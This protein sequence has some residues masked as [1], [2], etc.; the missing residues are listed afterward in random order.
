MNQILAAW[1]EPILPPKHEKFATTHAYL[2]LIWFSPF[3]DFRSLA[4]LNFIIHPSA[5][6]FL[7]THPTGT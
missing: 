4:T 3:K 7:P 5:D 6:S 2:S 1:N